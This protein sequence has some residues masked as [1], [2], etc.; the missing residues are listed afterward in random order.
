MTS[1]L[2]TP[3]EAQ[4][5]ATQL[6]EIAASILP[7]GTRHWQEDDEVRFEHSCGLSINLKGRGWCMHGVVVNGKT[8]GGHT[9]VGL[10][11]ALRG[12]RRQTAKE[13]VKAWVS[14]NPHPGSILEIPDDEIDQDPHP[15]GRASAERI[16]ARKMP[17]ADTLTDQY[18]LSRKLAPPYPEGLIAHLEHVKD[19]PG[20]CAIV[21]TLTS[22]GGGHIVGYQLGYLTTEATKS[23]IKPQ[24]RRLMLERCPDPC[25]YVPAPPGPADTAFNL[26]IC[27]GVENA[28]SLYTLGRRLPIVGVPGVNIIGKLPVAK[29]SKV[30]LFRDGDKP[31]SGPDKARIT[32]QDDLLLRGCE[33]W[34]TDT[35]SGQDPN[36]ILQK[37][38]R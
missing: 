20:E 37:G 8:A 11:Q 30:L 7:L 16:A 24:R 28:L 25:F 33:V 18:L 29:G 17:S 5:A 2:L 32:G 19:R 14:A 21:A 22:Y 9:A 3:Q 15:G 34:V 27:E 23:L 6:V 38:K 35:P 26:F 1:S 12:G 36:S 13:W 4:K 31:G 10:V